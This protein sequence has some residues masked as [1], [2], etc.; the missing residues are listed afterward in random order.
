MAPAWPAFTAS[1]LMIEN[2]LSLNG[3]TSF[4]AAESGGR[5]FLEDRGDGGPEVGRGLDHPDPRVR[6]R[7]HL[8]GRG[9][10]AAGDDG[11]RMAHAPPGRR[12]LPRDEADHRLLDLG[13]DEG[14]GLLLGIAPD[15][16][17][18]HDR[19]GPG[20]VAKEPQGVRV[21]GA[22]D[23]VAADADAGGL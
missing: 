4:A 6:H 8:L 10:L 5:L 14:G 16:A 20:V 15:L 21:V 23:R 3:L 11:P 1:G 12:G 19:L 13:L 22:D 17:D 2:V 18:H 9:P 7:T